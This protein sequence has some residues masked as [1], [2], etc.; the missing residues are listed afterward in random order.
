MYIRT[1]P[2]SAQAYRVVARRSGDLEE[3]KKGAAERS[4]DRKGCGLGAGDR[5]GRGWGAESC[6]CVGANWRC[7]HAALTIGRDHRTGN[8]RVSTWT[9]HTLDRKVVN[10]WMQNGGSHEK[11]MEGKECILGTSRQADPKLCED[12]GC[13]DE[14]LGREVL[15]W[16]HRRRRKYRS[17]GNL[18][19]SG[20]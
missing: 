3:K 1:S 14:A 19:Q 11:K 13:V 18:L 10:G 15:G 12:V 7:G 2:K 8:V 17:W 5:S 16:K 4:E 20:Q 6:S 9:A